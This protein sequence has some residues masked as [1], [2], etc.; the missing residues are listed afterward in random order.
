MAVERKDTSDTF[1][2]W[3]DPTERRDSDIVR[4]R[5]SEQ[6]SDTKMRDSIETGRRSNADH[7]D[8]ETNRK[9][10]SSRR[11]EPTAAERGV[12][13]YTSSSRRSHREREYTRYRERE[14]TI[15]FQF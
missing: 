10:V 9:D 2:H 5:A 6:D 13:E 4:R 11:S 14:K 12:P 7:Q 3:S 8:S 15:Q 1:D